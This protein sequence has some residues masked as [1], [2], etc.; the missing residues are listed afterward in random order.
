MANNATLKVHD[1]VK[2]MV[3]QLIGAKNGPG[4]AWNTAA[5]FVNHNFDTC[6]T[7]K[8]IFEVWHYDGVISLDE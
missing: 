3:D 6:F 7:P 1:D 2:E 8:Q 5:S 4:V